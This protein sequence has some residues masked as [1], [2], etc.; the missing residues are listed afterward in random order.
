MSG[1]SSHS[2][3]NVELTRELRGRNTAGQ[4]F[5]LI[6]LSQCPILNEHLRHVS[7]GGAELGFNA[8]A[9]VNARDF[10][11]NHY[12]PHEAAFV[13]LFFG[14]IYRPIAIIKV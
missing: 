8:T 10:R 3:V 14:A 1:E 6:P 7:R 9:N 13:N 11:N 12:C 2:L 4:A 5:P